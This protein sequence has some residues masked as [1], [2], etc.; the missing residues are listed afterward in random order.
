[1][2]VA[3]RCSYKVYRRGS[4]ELTAEQVIKRIEKMLEFIGYPNTFVTDNGPPFNSFKFSEFCKQVNSKLIHSPAY[5]PESN[6]QAEVSV[7]IV[8]SGLKKLEMEDPKKPTEEL[9]RK[10]LYH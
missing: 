8:K 2:F 10:F 6:G 5:H 3:C 1:M 7:K 4:N 9:V